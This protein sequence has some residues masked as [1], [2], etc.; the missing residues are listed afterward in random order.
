MAGQRPSHQPMGNSR[1]VN[2]QAVNSVGAEM[3]APGR[4]WCS[5]CQSRKG[6]RPC[7][8]K[9]CSRYSRSVQA[10]TP[11]A[12]Q[13][14]R[15]PSS[16]AGRHPAGAS[17]GP[18]PGMPAW[19]H[20]GGSLRGRPPALAQSSAI[21]WRGA[22]AD[23][24]VEGAGGRGCRM[25]RRRCRQQRLPLS[26]AQPADTAV[27]CLFDTAPRGRRPADRWR[28]GVAPNRA[29]WCWRAMPCDMPEPKASRLCGMRR[30]PGG[31]DAC[32]VGGLSGSGT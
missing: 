1:S 3:R 23:L 24:Q 22:L 20:S 19:W 5:A 18:A 27:F 11:A 30:R 16:Q 6:L 17:A 21:A 29:P 26:N 25:S 32:R 12:T 28:L 4:L 8:T 7:S 9:R 2:R 10:A 13:P 15:A 31:H 14:S